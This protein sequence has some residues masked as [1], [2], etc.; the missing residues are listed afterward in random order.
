MFCRSCCVLLFWSLQLQSNMLMLKGDDMA[1]LTGFQTLMKDYNK[2]LRPN[3]NEKPIEIAVTLEVASINAVS[4]ENMDYTATIILRQRWTDERLVFEGNRSITLDAR[5]VESLWVPDTYIVDS[6]KSFLHDVT[7]EN[8]L[9]RL[10]ANGTVLYAI[11]I[12]TTVACNMDLTKYPMDRQTCKLQL[13]SWGYSDKDLTYAWMRANDSVRGMDKLQLAQYTVEQYYT[14]TSE[15]KDETGTYPRLGLYFILRRNV[16][17]FIL[18]TYIPSALLVILSWVSFWISM[19]SVPARTCFGVTTVLAMTTILMG[20]RFNF[21]TANCIIKAVDVYLGI[22]FS[23]VFAALL[24]YAFA[25]YCGELKSA[26]NTEEI[27]N[28]LEE[29]QNDGSSVLI[30]FDSKQLNGKKNQSEC[31]P[32]IKSQKHSLLFKLR[33]KI[34]KIKL[35]KFKVANPENVDRYSRTV[36]PLIFVLI[37]IIYWAYYLLI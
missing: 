15:G 4:E 35:K 30:T 21:P 2:Y 1:A 11:R 13:E 20:S 16:V 22:C 5:L 25:H 32:D 17:Y 33:L 6:K 18:E 12:T 23:F 10:F 8:R 31:T 3:F 19:S 9:V 36:F 24:E 14:K 29:P 7:V 26:V 34:K 28:S 27:K 37:N